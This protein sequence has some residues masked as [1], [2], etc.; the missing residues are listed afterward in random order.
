MKFL[1]KQIG[2]IIYFLIWVLLVAMF[3]IN[4]GDSSNA[5]GFGLLAFW[6][7]MPLSSFVI[8]FLY[9][10]KEGGKRWGIIPIFGIMTILCQSLTF[11]LANT[12]SSGK[13]H[14]PEWKLVFLGGIPA[15]L[16]MGLG[17]MIKKRKK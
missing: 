5:M 7:V 9:G 14:I 15:F 11:D 17:S 16:G 6:I 8:A 13:L 4:M 10:K 12:L 3:W 1:R 2:V